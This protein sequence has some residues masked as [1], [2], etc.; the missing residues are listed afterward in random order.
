MIQKIK[1]WKKFEQ[2]LRFKAMEESG[3]ANER[4]IYDELVYLVDAI[5]NFRIKEIIGEHGYPTHKLLGKQGMKDFWLLV[6]HQDE[7]LEL[8]Q[9]CLSNCD[10]ASIERAYLTD[11]ILLAEGKK[12]IYGTQFT[13]KNKKLVL[14]PVRNRKDIDK[15]RKKAGL[16]TLAEY[17]KKMS[18]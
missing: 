3:G 12:Q 9:S 15:L 18:R 8:Q 5:N 10:F 17:T 14:R 16:E 2:K 11:R 1:R 6:Q 7:D 13:R 4:G